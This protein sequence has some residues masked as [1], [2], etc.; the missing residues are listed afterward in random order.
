MWF[1]YEKRLPHNPL[2]CNDRSDTV[3]EM[4]HDVVEEHGY[5]LRGT[6]GGHEVRVGKSAWI[7]GERQPAWV[8]QVRRR[9]DLDGSLTVF[10]AIDGEAA[11]AFLLPSKPRSAHTWRNSTIDGQPLLACLVEDCLRAV[12]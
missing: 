2:G 8:R 9:A 3:L 12:R 6:V 11:G 4:P 10:V 5:G 1:R 7:V